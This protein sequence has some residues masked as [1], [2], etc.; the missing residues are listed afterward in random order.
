ME[1]VVKLKAVL[2]NKREDDENGNSYSN[3]WF[4]ELESD[5]NSDFLFNEFLGEIMIDQN[6]VLEYLEHRDSMEVYQK[7]TCINFR[8]E[9][10]PPD[11]EI[12]KEGLKNLI[13]WV[14]D[15]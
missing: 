15:G 4:L 5:I 9:S 2:R 14:N 12:I 6:I 8:C 1:R 13:K 10:G 7:K 11:L 3:S